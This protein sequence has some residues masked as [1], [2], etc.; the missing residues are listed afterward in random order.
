MNKLFQVAEVFYS[1]QGEGLQSGVP[2]VFV[3]FAGC[4]LR[5]RQNS[6]GFD[7]DT[8]F[9]GGAAMTAEEILEACAEA[10]WQWRH[11]LPEWLLWTGGEPG[12]QLTEELVCAAREAG[13]KQAVETNGTR[14]LPA[15]L[16]WITVSP[17][18]AAH[19]L[20]LR[21]ATEVKCVRAHGQALP[22]LPITATYYLISPACQPEG[23]FRAEDVA[24]CLNLVRENPMWRLSLQWQKLLSIR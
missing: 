7:C 21:E 10:V 24:W 9:S 18:T 5:C 14:P 2:M 19:T 12:L 22:V 16:D 4:N 3:R 23:N 11:A 17:K 15:G 1:I 20:R 13:W 6:H 8:D